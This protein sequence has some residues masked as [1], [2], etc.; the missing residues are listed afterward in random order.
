[1]MWLMSGS[2]GMEGLQCLVELDAF[3]GIGQSS[4]GA[5]VGRGLGTWR[6]WRESWPE[7]NGRGPR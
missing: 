7:T 6:G 4:V 1:M 5:K 2:K 3:E